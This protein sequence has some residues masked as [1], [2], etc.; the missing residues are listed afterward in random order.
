[1]PTAARTEG[2]TEP[3]WGYEDVGLLFLMLAVFNLLSRVAVRI[4]WCLPQTLADPPLWLQALVPAALLVGLY[5]ILRSRYRR[6][7]WSALGWVTPHMSHATLAA[8]TGFGLAAVLFAAERYGVHAVSPDRPWQF[9]LMATTLGPIVEES[10]LRGFLL[11]LL[12]RTLGNCCAVLAV[13][14]LFAML[15]GPGTPNQWCWFTLCGAAYG[16]LRLRS[17]TTSAP[18]IMHA[19]YNLVLLSLSTL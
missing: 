11:P 18:A 9:W 7:V 4:G 6:T 2:G 5:A 1:M 10:V 19:T 3:Y 16:V 14:L 13:A 15:H 12:S 8:A 17:G